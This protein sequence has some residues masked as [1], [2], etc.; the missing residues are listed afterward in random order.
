MTT[1]PTVHFHR[2]QRIVTELQAM[3]SEEESLRDELFLLVK[4]KH[5]GA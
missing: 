3:R 1:V 2:A 4:G 5:H